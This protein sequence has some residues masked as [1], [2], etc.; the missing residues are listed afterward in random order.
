M[1]FRCSLTCG[2][3]DSRLISALAPPH[4]T[5]GT[6]STLTGPKDAQV[7]QHILKLLFMVMI[8]IIEMAQELIVMPGRH[9]QPKRHVEHYVAD[10]YRFVASIAEKLDKGRYLRYS[11]L[12]LPGLLPTL[13]RHGALYLSVLDG[14]VISVTTNNNS[15]LS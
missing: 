1:Q 15:V 12:T 5:L 9:A 14:A 13:I 4:Q 8:S 2:C 3:Q 11:Y 6:S 7:F 10:D